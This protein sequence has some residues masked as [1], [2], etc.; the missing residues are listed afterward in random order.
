M[1]LDDVREHG[2]LEARFDLVRGGAERPAA[3][4]AG[5]AGGV[6]GE[7]L[8]FH[9]PR[10]ER[11]ELHDQPFDGSRGRD[12]LEPCLEWCGDPRSVRRGIFEGDLTEPGRSLL[13]RGARA[14]PQRGGW[15]GGFVFG[16]GANQGGG[17][18]R[19]AATAG[20]LDVAT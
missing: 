3:A 13:Q 12:R 2:A 10:R 20:R 9:G 6:A 16:W 4:G 11:G 18:P 19:P 14:F 15:T 8:Q 5:G 1:D 7:E 17:I